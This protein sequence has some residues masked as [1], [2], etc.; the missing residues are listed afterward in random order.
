MNPQTKRLIGVIVFTLLYPAM[1]PLVEYIPNPMVPGAIVAL[2]MIFPVLAG[3]FYGPLSGAVAG[4][5]GTALAALLR[6]SMFDG[7][8][9]FPHIAM[10]L[11]AGWTGKYRSEILSSITILVGHA[12]NMLFFL[13]LE[14]FT[15]PAEEVGVTLLGLAAE[16]MI[17]IITIVLVIVLLKRWLYHTER[18]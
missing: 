16:T 6:V 14:L 5:V 11:A 7:L 8:A 10:G 4:G 2:N 1:A 12:L 13:R 9:I 18:W 3:Y 15:I 17:D